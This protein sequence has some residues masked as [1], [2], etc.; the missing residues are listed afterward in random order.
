M[1]ILGGVLW[2]LVNGSDPVKY[3]GGGNKNY[4][5]EVSDALILMGIK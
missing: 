3:N 1:S 4:G 2:Y 5:K